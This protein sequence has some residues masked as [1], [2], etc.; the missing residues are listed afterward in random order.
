MPAAHRGDGEQAAAYAGEHSAQRGRGQEVQ[1]GAVE[2]THI[3]IDGDAVDDL[4]P[5]AKGGSNIES[6]GI[7]Q[8]GGK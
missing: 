4:P 8:G 1:D 2:G 7:K 5:K 3:A 6:E